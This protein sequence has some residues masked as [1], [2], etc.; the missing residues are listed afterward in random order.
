MASPSNDVG[1][2]S[3]HTSPPA[4]AAAVV[5]ATG[6]ILL[7][8]VTIQFCTQCKWLL[9][10]AY[11]RCFFLLV[12]SV[13]RQTYTIFSPFRVPFSFSYFPNSLL[14]RSP[15]P[16][17]LHPICT[18]MPFPPHT[19]P[20]YPSHLRSSPPPPSIPPFRS[21]IPHPHNHPHK[22]PSYNPPHL[23]TPSHQPPPIT[24]L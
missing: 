1:A 24:P 6:T 18:P 13:P 19:H 15:G 8:R 23:P 14:L 12:L 16:Q 17:S 20:P 9:R 7:P 10:A 3:S 11:V 5:T 22:P 21:P 4:P 2:S